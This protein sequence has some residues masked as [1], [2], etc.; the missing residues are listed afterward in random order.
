MMKAKE[1]IEAGF[2][3][4]G[5]IRDLLETQKFRREDIDIHYREISGFCESTFLVE[6]EG[7]ETKVRAWFDTLHKI[8]GRMQ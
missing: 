3:V 8:I 7:P 5:A 6:V 1:R 2:L 4:R